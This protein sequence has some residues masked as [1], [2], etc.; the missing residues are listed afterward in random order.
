MILIVFYLDL[1]FI[2]LSLFVVIKTHSFISLFAAMFRYP[3]PSTSSM[4]ARHLVLLLLLLPIGT[5]AFLVD[6]S[7]QGRQRL[8]DVYALVSQIVRIKLKVRSTCILTKKR[9]IF[10]CKTKSK[11]E[12]GEYLFYD[13]AMILARLTLQKE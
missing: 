9:L 2:S 13:L 8:N 3:R 4:C 10:F 11:E 12:H 6:S 7:Q 5:L 1:L